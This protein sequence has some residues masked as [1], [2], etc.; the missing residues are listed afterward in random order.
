MAY[1]YNV[2]CIL[3]HVSVRI[4]M[5][6]YM[7][8]YGMGC[9]VMSNNFMTRKSVLISLMYIWTPTKY[10]ETHPGR[11]YLFTTRKIKDE[12]WFLW[13]YILS[14][15][16]QMCFVCIWNMCICSPL[17]IKSNRSNSQK[18]QSFL[19]HLPSLRVCIPFM[20]VCSCS[21]WD[22]VLWMVYMC[23]SHI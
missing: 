20:S 4:R 18:K 2:F 17:F 8:L 21:Y 13:V 22:F 7:H 1:V 15:S 14:I 12:R 16:K 3:N 5:Q 23:V 9:N 6:A 19:S 11:I 10:F